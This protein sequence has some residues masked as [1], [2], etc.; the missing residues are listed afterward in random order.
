MSVPLL[1]AGIVQQASIPS[2]IDRP[3]DSPN[4]RL[5]NGKGQR[6]SKVRNHLT[7]PR[8]VGKDGGFQRAQPVLRELPANWAQGLLM[9]LSLRERLTMLMPPSVF[10]R[11][12]IAQEARTGEPE[13]AVLAELVPRGGIAVDVGANVGF[14]AYALADIADHVVAFEPNPDY[15]FFARWMLRGRA[16]VR[17]IALSDAPGRGTLYVPLSDQG[18]LLHL[19]GSLKRSHVQF[20]N[21]KTYDVEIRTL[22]EAGLVGVHFVKADVEG[23]EREVLDG[24]RATIARDRP[25]IMLELL[26]GT[27]EN[28]AADVA[29]ICESF[30]YEAFIVQRGEK[31][32]ALPAI[33]ALGKNTSWGTEIE[34]RN[35]LF[36]P[37]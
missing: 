6:T 30:G 31:I 36:L 4:E 33:S 2:Q 23:G 24:A 5:W 1:G 20:R 29:A 14:F 34:S 21:T 3:F 25:I 9:P 22:D 8:F 7:V 32:A 10:Y 37:R 15:A 19:A 28:P 16:E 26:S 13:L 27:H 18:M 35:V 11:Q 17:E 12:R